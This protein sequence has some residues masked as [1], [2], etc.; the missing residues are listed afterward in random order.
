MSLCSDHQAGLHH[1]SVELAH[2]S[3]KHLGLPHRRS[4]CLLGMGNVL[5]RP[6]DHH[7]LHWDPVLLLPGWKS[8]S[9]GQRNTHRALFE[10]LT[11][12]FDVFGSQPRACHVDVYR[13]VI[14]DMFFS[15]GHDMILSEPSPCLKRADVGFG[16]LSCSDLTCW[17]QCM[18]VVMANPLIVGC[19]TDMDLHILKNTLF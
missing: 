3:G 1:G 18:N 4:L 6:W 16:C 14:H 5:H 9:V 15:S 17:Q 8:V 13:H 11:L 19:L 12:L 2:L 7:R 10:R